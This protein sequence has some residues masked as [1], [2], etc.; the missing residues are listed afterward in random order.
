MWVEYWAV[1]EERQYL[2]ATCRGREEK[3]LVVGGRSKVGPGRSYESTVK[4]RHGTAARTGLIV[5]TDWVE[6]MRIWYS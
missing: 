4:L 6:W 1:L 2:R 5:A 3:G